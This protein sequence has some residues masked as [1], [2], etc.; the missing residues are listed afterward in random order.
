MRHVFIIAEAGVNHNGS[1]DI[2]FKL[3]DAAK[4]AGAD[5]IKFQSFKADSLVTKTALKAAYQEKSTDIKESQYEMI[6]RLEL[7]E[8]D[9]KV[10][11]SYCRQKEIDFLSSPFDLQS[12]DLLSNLNLNVF[13]VPSGE[14][15]N[16]PYLR[17]IGKLKKAVLLST[18]MSTLCEIE[19]ALE[20]LISGGTDKNNITILHCNTEYPTPMEDVNLNAMLTIKDAFKVKV[21]YSDHT[22]GLEIA[23]AA[24]ALGASVIEKHFTLDQ[25]MDGPDHKASIEPEEFKRMVLAIRNL[26]SAMGDGIKK[27][28]KS[29]MKNIK[30]ARK[31]II[32]AKDIAEGEFF[33]EE[34]LCIKRPGTGLSPLLWDLLLG[35]KSTRNYSADDLISL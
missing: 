7:S 24:I 28:S 34:N 6:K 14:I 30:I 15:T 3:I 35:K 22:A 17:K 21:G 12:I 13:K 11:I 5:A 10:L 1:L 32:A 25:K 4:E 27:P 23:I 20:I 33:T 19:S 2:A 26:E 29:E 9:H 18:G 16:L 8:S 31:S